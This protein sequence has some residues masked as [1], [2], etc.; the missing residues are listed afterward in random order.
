MPAWINPADEHIWEKAK[1]AVDKTKYDNETYWK[2]VMDT[3][4]KMGGRR[5]KK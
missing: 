3:F 4:F 5:K 1:K 2:I